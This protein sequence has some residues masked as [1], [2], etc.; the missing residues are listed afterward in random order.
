MKDS[1]K[2]LLKKYPIADKLKE[3]ELE[4]ISQLM[5]IERYKAGELLTKQ[6][7]L[8]NDLLFLD[9]GVV[10][11]IKKDGKRQLVLHE[12]T[13][14]SIIGEMAFINEKKRTADVVA[15][16]DVTVIKLKKE[17]LNTV[18]SELLKYKFMISL[19]QITID[20][21]DTGSKKMLEEVYLRTRFAKTVILLIAAIGLMNF[22]VAFNKVLQE[23]VPYGV[24]ATMG[25]LVAGVIAFYIV[26][27]VER[28]LSCFGLNL[29]KWKRSLLEGIII[30]LLLLF[31]FDFVWE[32]QLW[33]EISVVISLG[34]ARYL[35]SCI[36]QEFLIR[37]LLQT[38][39]Q[40]FYQDSKGYL[41][42]LIVSFVTTLYHMHLGLLTTLLSF[43]MSVFLGFIYLRHKNLI[44]VVVIH[45][46]IGTIAYF[47]G[48]FD[49]A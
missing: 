41:S 32:R 28:P 36:M 22:I 45:F 14:P 46:S 33:H 3:D 7:S 20:R 44:G 6:D 42:I 26:K 16:S 19:S 15:Q 27:V 47:L 40:E 1:I 2:V 34:G 24:I 38:S 31:I 17:A 11:A 25:Y 5:T 48:F 23:Y 4:K 35:F 12:I 49:Q 21:L 9:E 29:Y 8:A 37:G 39:M 30:G 13:S 43:V 18:E 10:R